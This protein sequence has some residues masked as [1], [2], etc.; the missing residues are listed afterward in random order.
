MATHQGLG[1]DHLSAPQHAAPARVRGGAGA[2][3]HA[4]KER[5]LAVRCLSRSGVHWQEA[6]ALARLGQPYTM[7]APSQVTGHLEPGHAKGTSDTSCQPLEMGKIH[8]QVS[9]RKLRMSENI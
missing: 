2:P 8:E 4:D 5:G 3:C 1:K 9:H 6:L 7:S